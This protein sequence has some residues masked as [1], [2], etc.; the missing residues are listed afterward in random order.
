MAEHASAPRDGEG[1]APVTFRELAAP[2]RGRVLLAGALSALGAVGGVLP[3][4][5]AMDL[6]R[7]LLGRADGA[8]T[9]VAVVGLVAS[10][11][12]SQALT[13]TGYGISHLADARLAEELRLR[14]IDQALRLRLDWFARAGSGRVTK[15]IQ[16]DVAKVHQLIAHLIP[17]TANGLVRP[18]AS[19]VL[20]FVIDWRIGLIA[21][22]PLALAIAS[23]PL[24]LRNM[25]TRFAQYNAA[26][27]DLS[28]AVVE[29]VRGIAPI[30][31][32]EVSERGHE[33]FSRSAR[34]HHRMYSEWMESTTRGSALMM[35]FTSP[36]FAIVVSAVGA[37]LL[38]V[39][40]ADP[41]LLLPAVLLSANI[42]GPLYLMMQMT[43]FLRE[44]RGAAASIVDFLRM[45][46]QPDGDPTARPEG[47]GVELDAVEFRYAD[48]PTALDGV[49]LE[50]TEGTVTALVGPSGSGKSTLASIVPRLLDPD[51]G[52][53]RIG[54]VDTRSLPAAELYRRVA[55]VFQRPYLLRL[56]VRDN[57]RLAR[58]D[59]DE[60]Q[61]VAAARSAQI[62]E[63][64]LR[65]PRGYDTIVGEEAT[66]SGG[67]QQRLSI[68]RAI[69]MDAPVLVL[70][71]AT[72]FA[73][74]DSEAD[75][76]RALAE[77]TRGRTLLVVAHRLHTI[78]S[79]EQ[80][81]V[82]ERGELAER[83]TH[84]QLLERDGLYARMWRSYQIARDR[85]DVPEEGD[86]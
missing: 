39:A 79:A 20:L 6:V 62:H 9:L 14:Q 35:A 66:L 22:I 29:F 18:L 52:R 36:A 15:V 78:A 57:I 63:R 49:S 12:V 33:R 30:K 11:V 2:V 31:V 1:A 41:L 53:V 44:A 71:E 70:D 24:M 86:R 5:F 10:V 55:F 38:I 56:S 40:G 82:L 54:G 45:P 72:S 84:D 76:Q 65:L 83:G 67:E 74:P 81:A 25:A 80:I 46:G 77:L 58:P 50:L 4:L 43:Q 68:A 13:V 61:V 48:G 23:L 85:G 28:S 19:V 42:A 51:E 64:V 75:I 60:A 37:S 27:A 69:L 34:N 59:A 16:A 32:F 7:S 26:L 47:S 21:L 73:D 3:V 17:D 8:D